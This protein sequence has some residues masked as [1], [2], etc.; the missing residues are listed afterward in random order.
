M[1][2][3]KLRLFRPNK[4]RSDREITKSMFLQLR[5]PRQANAMIDNEGDHRT[6][7]LMYPNDIDDPESLARV[8]SHETLHSALFDV[9]EKEASFRLDTRRS[10]PWTPLPVKQRLTREGLY[11]YGG[12]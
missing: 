6:I 8:L 11:H 2:N 3:M 1:Q 9:G 4:Y 10:D 12:Y 7:I 5:S